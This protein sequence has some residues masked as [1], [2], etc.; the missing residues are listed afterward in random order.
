MCGPVR[1]FHL[2]VSPDVPKE[3]SFLLALT[4]SP[5]DLQEADEKGENPGN[6]DVEEGTDADP[7]SLTRPTELNEE[8]AYLRPPKRVKLKGL[9]P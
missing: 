9:Q 2:V 4:A 3:P 6:N 8:C 7:S 5:D 1:F